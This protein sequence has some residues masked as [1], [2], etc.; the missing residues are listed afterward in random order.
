MGYQNICRLLTA[1]FQVDRKQPI[2]TWEDLSACH[3]GLLVSPAAAGQPCGRRCSGKYQAA[4]EHVKK[5]IGIF[6]RENIY[7]EMINS[8][9]PKTKT[10]LAA[11]AELSE[12]VKLPLAAT[13]DVHY[14]AKHD[15]R[16]YD[17][18]VCAR[19]LTQLNDIHPERPL[20]AENYFASPA[21]MAQRFR[22]YPEAIA[23]TKE[24]AE[25][26]E[27]SL[28]LD[29]NLFPRYPLP[30]GFRSAGQLLRH[31]VFRGA[32]KRYGR[33]T[34]RIEKRLNHELSIID[35]LDVNDYFLVWDVPPVPQK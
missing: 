7:L 6:G 15:F 28:T 26:C 1:G 19:T 24:I 34:P 9:L 2:V 25:R 14:L 3:Q 16:L 5:L 12:H 17:L 33:I 8:Y 30:K 20:N 10:V 21:E 13:N 22:Q 31:L 18:M 11:I 23:N 35:Q 29:R 27:V 4:L 32:V